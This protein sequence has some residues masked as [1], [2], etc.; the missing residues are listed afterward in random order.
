MLRS[1]VSGLLAALIAGHALAAPP[2]LAGRSEGEPPTERKKPA[3]PP[4]WTSS[5][6]A[7]AKPRTM[8]RPR[9]SPS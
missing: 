7:C 1:V 4:V 8:R 9:A 2:G 3:P 5:S 6:D